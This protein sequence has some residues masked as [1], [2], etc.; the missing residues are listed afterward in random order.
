MSFGPL[1]WW[2]LRTAPHDLRGRG[3]ISVGSQCL[4][5]QFEEGE[6]RRSILEM[7]ALSAKDATMS[8]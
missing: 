4:I 2:A 8:E 6:V 3:I 5:D 1:R 7:I